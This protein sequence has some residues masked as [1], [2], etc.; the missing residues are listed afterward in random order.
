MIPDDVMIAI[1]TIGSGAIGAALALGL[2]NAIDIAVLK[3]WRYE[4]EKNHKF[5]SIDWM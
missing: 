2:R 3:T 1:L 4:H 5:K